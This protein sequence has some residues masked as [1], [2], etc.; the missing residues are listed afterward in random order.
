LITF[1]DTPISVLGLV[2]RPSS[3]Y[4]EDLLQPSPLNLKNSE[5]L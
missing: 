5:F 3:I 4:D 1:L 2:R